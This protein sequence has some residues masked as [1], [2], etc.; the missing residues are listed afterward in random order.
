MSF[1]CFPVCYRRNCKQET[2]SFTAW[3]NELTRA[4]KCRNKIVGFKNHKSL[5]LFTKDFQTKTLV[6]T[7]SI[8]RYITA[9]RIFTADSI[10]IIMIFLIGVKHF[11]LKRRQMI[12]YNRTLFRFK[13][14][15]KYFSI[16]IS[17]FIAC[18]LSCLFNRTLPI[19]STVF[20]GEV[21]YAVIPIENTCRCLP[22]L[23]YWVCL[24]QHRK[25]GGE[26]VTWYLNFQVLPRLFLK[27]S[28]LIFICWSKR[29]ILTSIEFLR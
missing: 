24:G 9:T 26:C 2:S 8:A 13:S 25:N 18:S 17:I 15:T 7:R 14:G 16:F 11:M 23:V 4:C 21:R 3:G 1:W 5:S 27:S 28:K 20:R 29:K 6:H 22:V 10:T 19:F 12:H